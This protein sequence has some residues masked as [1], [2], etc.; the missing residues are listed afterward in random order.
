MKTHSTIMKFVVVFLLSLASITSFSQESQ[1]SDAGGPP[2]LNELIGF[3][4]MV[5]L[6][7]KDKLNKVNPWPQPFHWVWVLCFW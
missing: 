7:N 2:S 1:K 4:K 6:P 3:W 5:D